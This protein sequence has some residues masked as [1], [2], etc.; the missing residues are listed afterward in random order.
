M[1][2]ETESAENSEKLMRMRHSASHILAE[3]VKSIFPDAK[4][5]IGPAI[6][7][8]FYYDFEL[9]RPLTP[10][11]LP[12]IESK[13]KE[14]VK[15]NLPFRYEEVSKDKAREI[16]HDQP[17]KLEL[18]DDIP[19]DKLGIYSQGSFVDLCRGPHVRYT[20]EVKAFK[21]TG[22]AGAYWKGDEK[23]PMLQRIYGIAFSKKQEVEDYLHKQE[24]AA[25]RDHRLINKQLNLYI[26]PEEIGSGLII[27]GPKGGR[28]RSVIEEFWRQEH[29][30]NGY[31]IL[32]SP[33]IGLSKLWEISGHLENYKENMYSPIDI[34]DQKYYVKPMNCPF[35]ILVYK[36][37][38]RSYR[39]LP[40]RWA[41]LGTVYRYE[42]S[43]V[44]HGLLRVRGFT[45][46][47]AHLYCLP[48]QMP[49][50]IDRVLAFSL[51][52]LRSFGFEDFNLYLATRP[53]E[54]Y[55]GGE[56]NW[57]DA[58]AAL[59]ASL[60]RAG[61]DY[62]VDEGGGAFY[63]PKIDI[64]IQD[65]LG[66]EWQCST[67]QFDFNLPERFDI[68]Y[69]GPDG[70]K[71]RPY[72]IHRA[73]FGSLERF[74]G[75]LIEYYAGRFPLWLSPVQIQLLTV[76]GDAADHAVALKESMMKEGVRAEADLRDETI[77]YKIRDAIEKKVPYI[78]VIGKKE[79]EN[80]TVSLRKRGEQSSLSVGVE[81]LIALIKEETGNKIIF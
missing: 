68:T 81:E 2:S 33:H 61:L 53:A 63:G 17:Y 59:E 36:S 37:Q 76:T 29:F 35:H 69:V 58:T 11:D 72:M 23:R 20:S 6:E 79:L 38:M 40:L 41:E 12:V 19:D 45:Q 78:G 66:R 9:P 1:A 64:K 42:R 28:I 22:I 43:G 8:G 55:V 71:H 51:F 50:E 73:L 56:N 27:Y 18:I 7:T 47:D 13:M 15:S 62:E 74:I 49:A 80:G 32:Y 4:L 70:Q 60:K 67:I 21:L 5:G 46:D 44:L 65:A 39:D 34:D 16:F 14:I 25:K 24:E 57:K 3:A 31:E 54:K 26:A 48:E 30:K 10:E 77:G 52:M 75:V